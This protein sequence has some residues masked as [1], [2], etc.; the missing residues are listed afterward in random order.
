M[1][2]LPEKLMICAIILSCGF[3]M[4]SEPTPQPS[5]E[6][7]ADVRMKRMKEATRYS[8]DLRNTRD[9]RRGDRAPW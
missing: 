9:A 3:V 4:Q 5:K 7:A 2:R 6:K 1:K 8:A